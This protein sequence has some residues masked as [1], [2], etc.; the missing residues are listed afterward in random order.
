M[1]VLTPLL[2][3]PTEILFDNPDLVK[4]TVYQIDLNTPTNFID[5]I[6]N[7]LMEAVLLALEIIV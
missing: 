1:V 5:F 6:T 3:I 7:K 4:D 2:I